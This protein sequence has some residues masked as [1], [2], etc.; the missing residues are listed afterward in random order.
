MKAKNAEAYRICDKPFASAEIANEA[1]RKFCEAVYALRVEH[2]IPNLLIT[3][4]LTFIEGGEENQA[5]VHSMMGDSAL[6]EQMAAY[7]FGRTSAER[8]A[9]VSHMIAEGSKD[10]I[11][12][13]PK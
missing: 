4:E 13:L 12:P 7:T 2:G 6:S 8:Q 9:R 10:A 5:M 1:M 11:K 3:I